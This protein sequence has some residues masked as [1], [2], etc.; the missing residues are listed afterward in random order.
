MSIWYKDSAMPPAVVRIK[1]RYI[2]IY[3]RNAKKRIGADGKPDI[4]Y[5]I[6][7]RKNGKQKFERVGWKSE[8]YSI[9]DAVKLRHRRIRELRHPELPKIANG[10][11]KTAYV[12]VYYRYGRNRIKGNG[13]PDICY[14]IHYKANGRYIWE[15]VGW[16]SEGYLVHDAVI[17][18]G[19]R[20]RNTRHPELQLMLQLQSPTVDADNQ[21]THVPPHTPEHAPSLTVNE[22]WIA[23][24]EQW[25]QNLKNIKGLEYAYWKHL[26]P[27]F[28]EKKFSEITLTEMER[29]KGV[30]LKKLAPGSVKIIFRFFR[31]IFNKCKEF[32]LISEDVK[33][34]KITMSNNLKGDRKRERYLTHD[35]ISKFFDCLSLISCE[36]YYIAK[37]SLY[38]GMRLHDIVNLKVYNIDIETGVIHIHESKTGERTAYIPDALKFGLKNI[39]AK[40]MN[41][42]LFSD[43]SGCKLKKKTLST[44]YSHIMNNI[45]LNNNINNR[46]YK[47]TFH[48]LRHTFCSWLAIDGVSI[49]TICQLVGHKSIEMTK[50][51]AKLSPDGM[52]A[53]L[54]NTF[55]KTNFTE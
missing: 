35:E 36:L 37:I 12:G 47:A 46:L 48:T 21:K 11:I 38:T 27:A 6:L 15:K 2:G 25:G 32:G 16:E 10:R 8:G 29:L 41:S 50:R 39:L 52:K 51:Y 43:K 53:V 14:D 22:A 9:L 45:G 18:R 7:Y 33:P 49:Y 28:G 24:K 54:N 1:T 4:C 13:K 55:R 30:L 40:N 20:I 5:D 23:Y 42:F 31:Q 3:Y 26:S 17:L 34:P 19:V 44:L